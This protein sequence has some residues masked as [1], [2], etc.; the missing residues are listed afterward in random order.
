MS[1]LHTQNLFIGVLATIIMDV[2]SVT[3]L[4]LGL[5]AFLPPR[6]TGRWFGLMAQ[7]HFVHSDIAQAPPISH[8]T[9]IAMPM[10]YAIGITL[11]IVYLLVT[12]ILGL[13]PPGYGVRLVR[14]LVSAV[15]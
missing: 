11:G 13:S 3:V 8:E 6:L 4:K 15:A 1:V 2:L 5:I 10:H 7:G 9:A 12:S 14:D